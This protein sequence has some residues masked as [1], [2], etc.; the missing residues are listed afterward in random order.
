M[1]YYISIEKNKEV[2]DYYKPMW[3]ARGV[4]GI[5]V[6][7]MTEG[8]RRAVE[9]EKSETDELFFI[10]IVADDIDFIP[11]LKLLSQETNAP[12]LVATSQEH[13]TVK[14]HHDALSNG[15]DFYAP[16]CGDPCGKP[17]DDIEGVL[18]AI[19]SANQRENKC[20][21][22]KKN[23]DYNIF[24]NTKIMAV[25]T[26]Q[27]V[28]DQQT[29]EWVKIGVGTLRVDTMNE[30]I[31]RLIRSEKFLFVAIN[32]DS[33]PDFWEQ[34]RVMR[35]VTNT[36]IFIITSNYAVAKHTK[37]V[38]YGADAYGLFA[39]DAMGDIS[40]GLELLKLQ[41]KWA[42]RPN[43]KLSVLIGGDV[44]LSE[45]RRIVFVKD[46]EVK[47]QKKEFEVLKVLM[48]HN[49]CFL[50]T[51]QILRI[52]WGEA[53]SDKPSKLSELR[54]RGCIFDIVGS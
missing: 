15:A 7:T 33:V 25:D 41:D 45:L 44:L 10:D 51:E 49:G 39:D 28:H 32:E 13:Y 4:E 2:F 43:Q 50:G 29:A 37:A 38:Q 20:K 24:M 27:A 14:E 19:S 18:S 52:V 17:E 26:N 31:S 6:E 11:Q 40:A 3:K 8:I 16:Y 53:Y 22:S 34:L 9:I 12:I 47:L 30:A 48:E 54:D 1:Q 5:M 21:I 23:N 35:D 42:S 36:P 46:T